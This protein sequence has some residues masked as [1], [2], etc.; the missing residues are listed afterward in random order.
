MSCTTN[1]DKKRGQAGRGRKGS[2]D[3]LKLVGEELGRQ[4]AK[5]VGNLDTGVG[6][7]DA[8]LQAQ[9]KG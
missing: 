8:H 2:L 9:G 5:I 3:H 1:Q 7:G 6:A 4:N